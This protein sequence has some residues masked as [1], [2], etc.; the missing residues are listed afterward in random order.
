MGKQRKSMVRIEKAARSDYTP[1]RTDED[2]QP[3]ASSPRLTLMSAA[4]YAPFV[5]S[6][7]RY[8]VR[9]NN[10]DLMEALGL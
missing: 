8:L 9:T 2:M 7:R 4:E 6:A 3:V 5:K 1:S 10:T